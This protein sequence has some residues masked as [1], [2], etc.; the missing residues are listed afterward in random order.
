MMVE[1]RPC[2]PT[3]KLTFSI[4]NVTRDKTIE[5]LGLI[6]FSNHSRYDIRVMLEDVKR[7]EFNKNILDTLITG[8]FVSCLANSEKGMFQFYQ[9]N[10][11]PEQDKDE[12]Q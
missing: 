10:V 4:T 8:Q 5:F 12:G 6:F 2:Y 3:D 7:S 11:V 9:E 1:T